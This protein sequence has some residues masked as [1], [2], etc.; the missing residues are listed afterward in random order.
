M[1]GTWVK[2]PQGCGRGGCLNLFLCMG[3]GVEKKTNVSEMIPFSRFGF[4]KCCALK[5]GY[6]LNGKT[7]A[8][9]LLSGACVWSNAGFLINRQI[10]SL[11]C[12]FARL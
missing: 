2:I 7:V 12:E 3:G 11:S 8:S 6:R 4:A 5:W 9:L 1:P 10:S